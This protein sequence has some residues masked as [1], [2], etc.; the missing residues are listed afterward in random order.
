MKKYFLFILAVV[1]SLSVFS[2][3]GNQ[4]ELSSSADIQGSHISLSD[5]KVLID[6]ADAT[7]DN[8][9]PVYVANDIVY[10]EEGRDFT[11]GEGE[12]SDEHSKEEA[13]RHLVVHITQAGN[14][15][16]SGS[17]KEGQI[18]IDL[19]KDAK[20]DPKA[21]V[22]LYLNGVDITST[23]APAVIFYNAYE[24]FYDVTEETAAKDVDTSSAG[25]NVFI[26][27]GTENNIQGSYVARIYKPDSVQLSEDGKSVEDAKKLHKYDA[28][29]YS[30]VTMNMNGGKNNTG[31]LNIKAENEGLDSEMHLTV[32][33]GIINIE[34][35]NDGINTNEDNISVATM[36]G[37]V[38]N[39]LVNG[40]TG[41]G[42]GIDSN[43]WLVINGGILTA[44]A[45]GF[46]MDSGIDSDKGIHINGG[47]VIASGNMLD[48]ISESSANYAVFNFSRFL[49]A[50]TYSLKNSDNFTVFQKDITNSFTTLIISGTDL[51]EGD[52]T[53][54]YGDNQLAGNKGE[55]GGMFG[56]GMRPGFSTGEIPKDMPFPENGG[57]RPDFGE[58]VPN[59]FTPPSEDFKGKG[60]GERAPGGNFGGNMQNQPSEL[61]EIFTIK[62]GENYF[63]FISIKE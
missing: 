16:L 51:A 11:Y 58:N 44:Q 57:K 7:N 10:Y 54:W 31:I 60:Q 19:G 47:T 26:I 25:A 38:L 49:G 63:S 59:S 1:M 41:E 12:K 14:Y 29:F 50:G 62:N 42:D 5:N 3:C 9:M 4:K 24:P 61:S 40:K 55:N 22:N 37:G 6:G 30:K 28:A 45:C 46:S 8:T 48:R 18:A 35:G 36:N 39:I 34:S 53:L 2:G 32:N 17:L 56:G 33:G 52:Y 27:D 43:G 23:V 13:G 15:I 21:V 20:E